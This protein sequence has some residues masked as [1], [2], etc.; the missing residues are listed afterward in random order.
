MRP[1][2]RRPRTVLLI[3]LGVA[4]L[5]VCWLVA[6]PVLSPRTEQM[7]TNDVPIAVDYRTSA[8]AADLGVPFYP[9][10][11][12]KDSFSYTIT[13]EGGK[14]VL[15]Y[16]SAILSSPDSP[17]R[18]ASSY[19]KKLPRHPQPEALEGE[20]GTRIVL[21]LAQGDEVKTITIT[22]LGSGSQIEIVHTNRPK[23]PAKP[24]EPKGSETVT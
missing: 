16:A 9:G 10:A 23:I 12:V 17:D 13:A 20:S 19:R 14:R 15:Y 3:S 22:P 11:K 2:L 4:L 5:A 1:S 6:A 8:S 7:K 21:A 24:L 18:I